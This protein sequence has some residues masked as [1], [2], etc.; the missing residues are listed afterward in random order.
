MCV[1]GDGERA[2]KNEIKLYSTKGGGKEN[3]IKF[4]AYD[5]KERSDRM[6]E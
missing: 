4:D 6:S 1:G 5:E 2:T 3:K